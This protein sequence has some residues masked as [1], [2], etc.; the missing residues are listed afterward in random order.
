MTI[1]APMEALKASIATVV[2]RAIRTFMFGSVRNL[3]DSHQGVPKPPDHIGC[4]RGV[5]I[6]SKA[7]EMQSYIGQDRVPE[8]RLFPPGKGNGLGADGAVPSNP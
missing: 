3:A 1:G 5:I 4:Y 2:T 7:V 6:N 8:V